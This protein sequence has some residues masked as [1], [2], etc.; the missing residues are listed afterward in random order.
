MGALGILYGK[1]IVD[2]LGIDAVNFVVDEN[3]FDRYQNKQISCNGEPCNFKVCKDKDAELTDLVIV[4]V[5]Y[6]SLDS[7][8]E[9]MKNSVGPNTIIM[10]VMNG[11]SSEE[12]IAEKY[13]ADKMIYTV[14]QGMD[15]MKFGDSLNF[16]KSGELR[17]GI[18]DSGL[19]ENLDAV[20]EFLDKVSLAYTLE[21]DILYRMWG[22][23]MLNVGVNQTCMVYETNYSGVLNVSEYKRTFI[24]AMREVI[25]IA[26]AEDINLGE[27]DINQYV[28]IIK[29]LSPTGVPSM[30]QDRINHN[31]SEVEM[32]AGTVIKIANKHNIHVP[33]NEFLYERVA[34]I[35]KEY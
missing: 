10:S 15:A 1:C 29:S 4:A 23:F 9:T 6:T 25:A 24:S 34:E 33:V 21:T 30:A 17:I 27:K 7:A 14:A 18:I 32:F 5:K 13:G 11:I 28:E 31:H 12:I 16:T 26:N 19:K 20:V 35:E 2:E 22:K 3:R 8:L